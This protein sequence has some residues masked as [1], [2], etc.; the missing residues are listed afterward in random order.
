MGITIH[1]RGK[2]DDLGKL[3]DLQRE[4]ADIAASVGWQ[5]QTLDDG[6]STPPNATLV[7][8]DGSVKIEGHL[9]LRGI[10]LI[11]PGSSEPVSF[12]FNSSGRLRS[13]MHVILQCEGHA[14]ADEDWTHVKTQFVPSDVHVWIV[15]LLKYIKKHYISDLEVSD[16]GDYWETG[17][18][19]AL[20]AK[21]RFL[22]ETMDW[23]AGELSSPR[24][25]DLAG[26]SATRL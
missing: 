20:E 10:N 22:N 18:R 14:V 15:G 5:S 21:L 19:A 26:K 11:P 2:L 23:L 12:L 3:T 7:H 24:F 6:W 1:Y 8:G 4:L 25:A 9:G 16:E 17:D 13:I